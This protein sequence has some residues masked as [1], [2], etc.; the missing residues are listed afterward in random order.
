[1]ALRAQCRCLLIRH[2]KSLYVDLMATMWMFL[3]ILS[4]ARILIPELLHALAPVRISRHI[5][6][7]F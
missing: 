2:T 1:M 3:R 6:R 5:Q 4:H 7:C